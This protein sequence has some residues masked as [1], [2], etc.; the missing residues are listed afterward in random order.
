MMTSHAVAGDLLVG[1]DI[2]LA[3]YFKDCT[4]YFF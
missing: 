2:Q 1:F 3:C 4:D